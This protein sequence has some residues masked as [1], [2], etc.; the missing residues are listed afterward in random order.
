MIA[1]LFMDETIPPVVR[2]ALRHIG[3]QLLITGSTDLLYGELLKGHPKNWDI[4][5]NSQK[6]GY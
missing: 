1:T 6:Q 2:L 4:I 5:E 3:N